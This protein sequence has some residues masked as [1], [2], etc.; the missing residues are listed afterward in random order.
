MTFNR[1]TRV[2][3]FT[4]PHCILPDL[5]RARFILKQ[6]AVAVIT[7]PFGEAKAIGVSL[8]ISC[9]KSPPL[10]TPQ[11]LAYM[12]HAHM[13]STILVRMGPATYTSAVI[14][15]HFARLD[16]RDLEHQRHTNLRRWEARDLYGQMIIRW[17]KL[18]HEEGD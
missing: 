8:G 7:T 18:F 13:S 2:R 11:R 4:R 9:G 10:P 5:Y 17:Y 12:I 1:E 15:P 6:A 14:V 3:Y 16:S